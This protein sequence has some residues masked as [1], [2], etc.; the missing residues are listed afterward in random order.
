[1]LDLEKKMDARSNDLVGNL[2]R[3]LERLL[4]ENFARTEENYKRTV[5]LINEL[6]SRTDDK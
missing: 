5:S 3:E 4:T 2:R 1:M 6:E